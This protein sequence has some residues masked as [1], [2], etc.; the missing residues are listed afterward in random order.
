MK[1]SKNFVESVKALLRE[2][3]IDNPEYRDMPEKKSDYSTRKVIG[4]V[5]LTE[6]RFRIKSEV[7][8]RAEKFA[9]V[10]LP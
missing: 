5:N 3:G 1:T 10:T 7:D 9:S 6:D 4:N 8:A 2:H